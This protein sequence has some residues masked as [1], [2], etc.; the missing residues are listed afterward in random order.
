[1]KSKTEFPISQIILSFILTLIFFSCNDRWEDGKFVVGEGG[2]IHSIVIPDNADEIIQ[3]AA[4]ELQSYLDRMTGTEL[5]IKKSST[6]TGKIKEIQ[7]IRKENKNVHWDGFIIET[8]KNG[9]L[10]SAAESRGLLY[11]VYAML[12]EAG[13][14]FFY[15]G[16]QEEIV[17]R[18]ATVEF[19]QGLKT[20]NPVLE[21]RGLAP[22]GLQGSSVGL[23]G[24]F[25]DWMAKN[26]MNYILI[27]EDRPSD[28]AGPAHG[29]IWKE[30][31][32]DLLP[33][34]QKRGFVIEM[35]EHCTHVFFPR[36]LH[37]H[38][39]DWF[40]LNN[41]E[42]KLGAPPYS[43]QMCYANSDAVEYYA[44]AIADYAAIHPE[45]HVIGTW[46]LD[47][48]EYCE[49]EKCKDPQ[50]VFN[51]AKQVAEKVKNVRPDM[52]VEHLAYKTQTWQPPTVAIPENM[53]VLWCPDIGK[54][55]DL[56]GDWVQ[57]TNHANGVYQFEYYM[58]DNYRS[59]ANVWLRPG[60]SA[61]LARHA[62]EIGFRGIVSLF[63]PMENWWRSCFNNWF[64]AR[65]CW[66]QDFD[67]NTGLK[68]YCQ[69]YYGKQA[70]EIEE[71]F[72]MLFT[73]LH[74]EPFIRLPDESNENLNLKV[75]QTSIKLLD[76]LD[77]LIEDAL[78]PDINERIIRLRTYVEFFQLYNEAMFKG[79]Q[80][81]LDGL[82]NYIEEH[83]DQDMVLMYP[84]YVRWRNGDFFD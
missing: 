25:I 43:G 29:S 74:P 47:G 9:I 54:M 66:D 6:V 3:F 70:V 72:H 51:A 15:P 78:D 14:S 26:R 62:T 40:A 31:T 33:E 23:G 45:F 28:S 46:P 2:N 37:E 30:V 27:S 63:L 79:K 61:N 5:Q 7:I 18:Q 35:S 24:D 39:P 32:N 4:T 11:G 58:G 84:D 42:R 81:D 52:V 57:K 50:T 65:A 83:P 38:H 13:C 49:C 80:T 10:V 67:I 22:Y 8:S 1:M 73:E 34:L 60:F 48:G 20:F 16:I 64:F 41:G 77:L 55:D 56:A 68:D 69:K 82:L 59:R 76:Q 36:S 71:I 44:S 12:E 75:Q 53:S 21:H 17:P 19:Q